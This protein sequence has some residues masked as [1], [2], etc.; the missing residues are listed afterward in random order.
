M[1]VDRREKMSVFNNK[2]MISGY[3][4]H[5]GMY[6]GGDFKRLFVR[7]S[8]FSYT[9]DEIPQYESISAQIMC[10]VDELG[11]ATTTSSHP[12]ALLNRQLFERLVKNLVEGMRISIHG[13]LR[14]AEQIFVNGKWHNIKD[15]TAEERNLYLTQATVKPITRNQ[16]YV[17]IEDVS[18][19]EKEKFMS[20]N[21]TL[22]PDAQMEGLTASEPEQADKIETDDNDPVDNDGVVVETEEEAE[23]GEATRINNPSTK[24]MNGY[25]PF[26]DMYYPEHEQKQSDMNLPFR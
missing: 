8:V 11:K 13:S 14:G 16:T 7:L 20:K 23:Q 5:V 10:S 2:V 17:Y 4:N 26:D 18:M 21:E 12:K 15:L 1:D 24:N 3:V 9:K 6:D 22:E 25:V 19:P